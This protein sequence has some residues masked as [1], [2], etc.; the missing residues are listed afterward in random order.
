MD[1]SG[2]T[3]PSPTPADRTNEEEIPGARMASL[4]AY[5]QVNRDRFTEA[6]L[7]RSSLEAGYTAAEVDAAWRG[8]AAAT[9]RDDPIRPRTNLLVTAGTAI[10]FIAGTWLALAIGESIN[11]ALGI[12]GPSA[13]LIW[14]AAGVIGTVGWVT[15]R[16]SHPSVAQ[17]LGCGVIL[18]IVFPLV[19]V[20]AVL[21]FCIATGVIPLTG[22]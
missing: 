5:L 4:T 20:L 11:Q 21:G 17:G 18:V 9:S 14:L 19:L 10:A 8:I 15:Q 3:V 2:P 12:Y 7:R 22:N 1:D 13:P 6:S 16:D